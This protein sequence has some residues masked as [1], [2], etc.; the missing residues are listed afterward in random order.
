MQFND[1]FFE[2]MGKSAGVERL[3]EDRADAVAAAAR[4]TAPVAEGD[5]RDGITVVKRESDKRTVFLVKGTNWKTML[6]ESKTGNLVRALR[7]AGRG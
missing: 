5:Y 7:R 2:Q 3:V 4:A 1:S 6:I